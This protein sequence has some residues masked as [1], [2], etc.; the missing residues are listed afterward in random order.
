MMNRNDVRHRFMLCCSG[1]WKGGG[2]RALLASATSMSDKI[3]SFPSLMV[4]GVGGRL[5]ASLSLCIYS[6]C[7]PVGKGQLHIV[8]VKLEQGG[9]AAPLLAHDTK[10]KLEGFTYV[11]MEKISKET[12]GY[13]GADLAA[14]CTKSALHCIREKMLE[15]KMHMKDIK[16][17]QKQPSLTDMGDMDMTSQQG[18]RWCSFT[19]RRDDMIASFNIQSQPTHSD[20]REQWINTRIT[21]MEYYIVILNNRDTSDKEH[22]KKHKCRHVKLS[23]LS[24]INVNRLSG[25]RT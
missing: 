22:L 21:Y 4:C 11:D 10:T 17:P 18:E 13:V 12:H 15:S 14:L 19:D 1:N 24:T 23:Y 2:V 9:L 25:L 8:Y 6:A 5:V 20:V 3:S 16:A 7:I